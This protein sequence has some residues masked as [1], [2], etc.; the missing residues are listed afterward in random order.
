[1]RRRLKAGGYQYPFSFELPE[2]LPGSFTFDRRFRAQIF[3]KA[4]LLLMPLLVCR[5][6]RCPVH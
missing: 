6:C 3:Y 2:G 5:A 1:M 4:R